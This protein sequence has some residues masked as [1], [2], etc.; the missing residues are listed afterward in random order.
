MANQ[1]KQETS[2]NYLE[3]VHALKSNPNLTSNH[4][5]VLDNMI[6]M[7]QF[8]HESNQSP[9]Y[10]VATDKHGVTGVLK[11]VQD[12]SSNEWTIHDVVGVPGKKAGR[13]LA[14][15]ALNYTRET[16]RYKRVY[17]ISLNKLST[18]FWQKYKF[19][20][21]DSKK[22]IETSLPMHKSASPSSGNTSGNSTGNSTN[23]SS[24]NIFGFKQVQ[25]H[26]G[27]EQY[28]YKPSGS[29]TYTPPVQG[30]PGPEQQYPQQQYA[31][32]SQQQGNV[33]YAN[34]SQPVVAS[35]SGTYVP[36]V[37]GDPGPQQQGYDALAQQMGGLAVA[38]GSGTYVPPVQ[39]G[40]G[41][42]Q[43]YTE[44]SIYN[45]SDYNSGLAYS[46]HDYSS[47]VNPD[48]AYGL[49]GSE[50]YSSGDTSNLAYGQH[51]FGNV[52]SGGDTSNLA[53]GLPGSE[54]Y[55]PGYTTQPSVS[56]MHPNTAQPSGSNMYDMTQVQTSTSRTGSPGSSGYR[57]GSSSDSKD[58]KKTKKRGKGKGRPS[59][60]G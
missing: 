31:H 17:L 45:S 29:G 49:P 33:S 5:E 43:K 53:Y 20:A 51:H 11:M 40:A 57:A 6:L 23:N 48:M 50:H 35:G 37:Q 39:G 30:H 46:P 24:G 26:S 9:I 36:H 3:A 13:D 10:L 4:H 55:S 58:E 15:I 56:D 38:S 28:V 12:L 25:G 2:E 47:G 34:Y 22:L 21:D 52:S 60:G 8:E 59:M 32:G 1:V 54:H 18:E 16:A 41:L 27:S 19:K 44:S 7:A 14:D 42:E